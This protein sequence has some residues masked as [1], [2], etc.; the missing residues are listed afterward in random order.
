MNGMRIAIW[1][2]AT[3][4]LQQS[5]GC[6]Q[7]Q[8]AAPA[9]A[10]KPIPYQRFVPVPRQP[11]DL[12]GVPWS[13]AFALDTKTGQLCLTYP[14]NFPEKWNSLPQCTDLLKGFPD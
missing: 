10:Q 9:V 5:D 6:N 4:V 13:G 3:L 12:M 1:I 7:V 14:G 2:I 11:A 8:P